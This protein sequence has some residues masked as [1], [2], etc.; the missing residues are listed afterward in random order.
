MKVYMDNAATTPLE[1]EVKNAM[2][3]VMES[4]HG[5]PSSIHNAGRKA[6]IVIEDARKRVAQNLKAST[7]EIFFTSSATESNNMVPDGSQTPRY[8]W[9]NRFPPE[10]H[11]SHE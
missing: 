11:K 8:K 7:G 9:S 4:T 1:T 3:E 6:R 10:S 5:N 2:M